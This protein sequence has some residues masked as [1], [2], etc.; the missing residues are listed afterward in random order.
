MNEEYVIIYSDKTV[1]KIHGI[2]VKGL[3]AG[4][5]EDMLSQRFQSVVRVIGVTGNSIDMDVYGMDEESILTDESG[6]IR[7][8]SLLDGI[9]ATELTK[10]ACAEKIV[11]VNFDS[12]PLP[13]KG[14]AKERWLHAAE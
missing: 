13:G 3:N 9:T 8:V 10:I 5:L 4:T 2:K 14:C 11:S 12:I 7:A 6:I 1:I